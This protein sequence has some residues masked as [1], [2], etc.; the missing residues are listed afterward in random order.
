MAKEKTYQYALTASE[1]RLFRFLRKLETDFE[2]EYPMIYH[3][4]DPRL[5]VANPTVDLLHN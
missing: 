2:A 3:G 1:C 4:T 5:F